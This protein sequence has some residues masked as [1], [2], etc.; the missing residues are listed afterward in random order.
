MRTGMALGVAG[1]VAIAY[2][3]LAPAQASADSNTIPAGGTLTVPFTLTKDVT[4][5]YHWTSS[6]SLNFEL[7]NPSGTVV[8]SSSGST[9]VDFYDPPTGG[10]YTF[11]WT[12]PSS[13]AATIEYDITSMDIGEDFFDAISPLFIG[14]IV[15]VV[16]VI[17]VVVAVVL[18][19]VMKERP[20][21]PQ[22][23]AGPMQPQQY[24]P[25]PVVGTNCPQCG[26]PIDSGSS[27]CARCGAKLR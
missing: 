22:Q 24:A 21:A 27:F 9:H 18:F 15:A 6:A 8:E 1:L 26:V 19:A 25:H 12:N 11:V 14:V 2:L 7:R 5:T 4:V 20:S 23:P 3:M 10:Q 13:V 16:L 17:I